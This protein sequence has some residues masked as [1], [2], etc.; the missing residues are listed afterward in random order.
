MNLQELYKSLL[1]TANMVVTPD[2]Y[3]SYQVGDATKPATVKGKRIVLPTPEHLANPDWK[4][5]VVFHPL[6][7]NTLRGESTILEEFR[8]SINKKLNFTIGLLAAELLTIASSIGEHSKLSPDQ[9]EF[10]SKLKNADEKSLESFYK[11][12]KAMP[13]DQKQNAFVSIFLKRGGTIGE[14][15][16]SRVGIV[17][18]PFYTELKTGTGDIY[19]VKI[20]VKDRETFINL[21]EYMFPVINEA[22][23]YN[24]GSD[25]TVAPYLDALMKS[26][27][28][29]ASA[30][31]DQVTLFS[32]VV[33]KSDSLLIEDGWVE[34][35]DN[36]AVM[37]PQIRMIPMQAGGEG[38][39]L[40]S[41]ATPTTPVASSGY[42]AP[43]PP[44]AIQNAFTSPVRPVNAWEQSS[45]SPSNGYPTQPVAPAVVRTSRGT[46]F[47]S[48]INSNP[49]L[50]QSIRGMG[51][52]PQ[53]N[54]DPRNTPRY[55]PV[56]NNFG[57]GNAWGGNSSAPYR[58][59]F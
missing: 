33:D 55:N 51:S 12:L 53:M 24:R 15:R 13:I 40:N 50:A 37:V 44:P 8:S 35:F 39:P 52:A 5:R 11:L 22:G 48:L 32:N 6:S 58:S 14:K 10:L 25:S 23:S 3:A 18:F 9:L 4:D 34:T 43:T 49:V 19:G 27:M 26:V 30:I 46:D 45:M 56:Q 29:I 7:E 38:S 36:L 57:G 16:H 21:M 42:I 1:K 20:R 17:T 59:N 47:H 41:P 54:V 31:N 2:G 28:S